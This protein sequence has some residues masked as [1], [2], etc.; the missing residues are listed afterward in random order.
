LGP[1]I[2]LPFINDL[3]KIINKTSAT[4]TF[5]DDSS[6][7]FVHEN[8]IDFNNIHIVFETLNE[9]FKANQLFL[10]IN[11]TNYVHF[12]TKINMSI[13]IQIG[14]NNNLITNSS[15][16]KFLGLIM[17]CTLSWNNHIEKIEYSLR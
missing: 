10:N 15:Y 9:R 12:A 14:F 16:T 8:I 3:S 11:K 13:N 7:L 2:F 17:D 5:V 4:I 1:L 6:I